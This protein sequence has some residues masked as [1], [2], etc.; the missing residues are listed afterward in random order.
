M[1]ECTKHVLAQLYYKHLYDYEKLTNNRSASQ[2]DGK[3]RD[4]HGKVKPDDH[5]LVSG[6]QMTGGT[7][8]VMPKRWMMGRLPVLT[9]ARRGEIKKLLNS[10]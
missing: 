8:R 7:S 10:F 9:I 2:D 1:P 5:S 6:S 4:Y 3:Q